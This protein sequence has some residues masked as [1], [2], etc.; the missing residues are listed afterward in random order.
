MR[1]VIWLVPLL[2]A[3]CTN[4]VAPRDIKPNIDPAP[5]CD[6]PTIPPGAVQ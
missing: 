1:K 2:L 5:C 4:P 6:L 3:A